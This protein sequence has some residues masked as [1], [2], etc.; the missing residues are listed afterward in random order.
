MSLQG[1]NLALNY[2]RRERNRNN[3]AAANEAISRPHSM[4]ITLLYKNYAGPKIQPAIP[5]A[6]APSL[7]PDSEGVMLKS[8]VVSVVVS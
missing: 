8:F 5:P 3:N 6:I 4:N 1:N 7:A 2:L